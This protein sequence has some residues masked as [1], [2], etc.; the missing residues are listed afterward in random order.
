MLILKRTSLHVSHVINELLAFFFGSSRSQVQK[1]QT[2]KIQNVSWT[3]ALRDG[4]I[5]LYRK[6][7]T[8]YSRKRVRLVSKVFKL[9]RKKFETCNTSRYGLVKKFESMIKNYSI[10]M[11]INF[12]SLKIHRI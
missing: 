11:K 4:F 9:Y 1:K 10:F 2:D 6:F 5:D 12:F 7:T 8:S 3:F